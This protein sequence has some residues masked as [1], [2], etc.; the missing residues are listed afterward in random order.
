MFWSAD[1]DIAYVGK[2]VWETYLSYIADGSVDIDGAF[3]AG[4]PISTANFVVL[5]TKRSLSLFDK[6]ASVARYGLNRRKDGQVGERTCTC[7]DVACKCKASPRACFVRFSKIFIIQEFLPS[8][9][10]VGRVDGAKWYIF[11]D[12]FIEKRM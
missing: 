11:Y 1:N 7:S 5:P 12:V 2:P 10:F 8:L 6:W 3:L 9:N 4:D